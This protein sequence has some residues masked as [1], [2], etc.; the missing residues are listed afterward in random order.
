VMCGMAREF[1][2]PEAVRVGT[3]GALWTLA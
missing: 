3:G 2:D 1:A